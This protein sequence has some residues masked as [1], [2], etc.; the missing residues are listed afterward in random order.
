MLLTVLPLLL[1]STSASTCIDDP[2][3]ADCKH[4]RYNATSD[5]SMVCSMMPTMSGCSVMHQCTLGGA[6]GAACDDFSL[7]HSM[8]ASMPKM[9]GCHAAVSLCKNGSVV[10]ACFDDPASLRRM[11]TASAALSADRQ[12]CEAMPSMAACSTCGSSPG[13]C[14]DPLLT[15]GE[16]CT[17]MP[18]DGCGVWQTWCQAPGSEHDLPAYCGGTKHRGGIPLMRMYFHTGIEEYILLKA[19]VPTSQPTYI[20]A[21]LLVL[22]AGIFSGWLRGLRM[23]FEAQEHMIVAKIGHGS[24]KAA[25]HTVLYTNAVRAILTFFSSGADYLLMLLAMTYVPPLANTLPP[26]PLGHS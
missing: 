20:L 1:A 15:L 16:L 3:S 22:L 10:E 12:I 8:C 9:M 19:W 13:A 18:M 26:L 14:H 7:L 11:P 21:V 4:Y 5:L 6:Q 17:A 25:G 24:T 2:S 23:I